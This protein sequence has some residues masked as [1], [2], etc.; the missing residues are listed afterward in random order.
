MLLLLLLTN[1]FVLLPWAGA[2]RIIGGREAVAHSRPYMAF[3]KIKNA[4]KTSRCGGFL[5][6]PDAVLSAAHCVD[7][8]GI[9]SFS[10]I[11][12]AHNISSQEPSQQKIP[13]G[14]WVIHP[15]YSRK[16]CINDIMLLKLKKKA[17]INEYVQYISFAK[18]NEHVRVGALC[19]VSGWGRTSLNPP[20]SD[21]LREVELKVQKEKICQKFSKYFQPQ[22]MICVGDEKSK[23]A[24]Y[25]GDSGGPLVCNKKAHGIVSH[26]RKYNLFPEVFTRIAHFEP[27]IRKQLTR[28]SLQDIPS[29]PAE[30]ASLELSSPLTIVSFTVILGAHNVSSQEPSQQKIPVGKWVIHPEYSR[31]GFINDI[32]LLKLKKKAKINEYV[33]YI[34]FAKENEHVRVGALCSVSGWGRTSLNPPASDV[35]REAEL[36]VQK[37]EICQQV[38]PNYKRQSMICVG[39]ENR[40]KATYKGDSGGP[41][42]C[43]KK[44]HGIVS[45]GIKHRLFPKAF[46]RISHFEPWIRKQLTRFALQD[47]PGSTSSD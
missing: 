31:E 35:L 9:V 14:K 26:A 21:V 10:V 20:A 38:F 29:F 42:V 5:I 3:L 37:Q 11:L 8:K 6:R 40:K 39:D 23:K 19:R 46:T 30:Q 4:T 43:N 16:G 18:E 25:K 47:I 33:Q 1:A 44:A 17:K 12:G 45:R 2:G 24:A 34:S 32:M 28:F 22:S 36:K 13:V 41:L 27:W 7:K 15:K